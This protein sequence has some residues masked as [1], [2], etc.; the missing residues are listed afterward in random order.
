MNTLHLKY[1]IE[2]E[3]T[4]SISQAA[5]N[6]FMGQPSLSKAIKELEDTLG[7]TIFERT[8][9]GVTPTR[10]GIKFLS[11]ARNVLHQ[12]EQMEA[13][14][15]SLDAG[16][17]TFN[18]SIPR[19]SYIADAVTSL[20]SELDRNE[21]MNVNV[22]ETN[23][24]QVV[25]NIIDGPFNLGVIRF[26]TEYEN[27]FK[28]YLTEK[29]LKFETVWEF[30]YLVLMSEKH[31]LAN[32]GKV[33]YQELRKYTEITHGDTAIP[34]IMPNSSAS[35]ELPSKTSKSIYVYERC[36]QYDLLSSIP[37]TYMWVSPIPEKW[38]QRYQLVQRKCKTLGN[39]YKD[40][41]IYPK[42][43]KFTELDRRFVNKL[44]EAKNDVTFC[45]Y[46]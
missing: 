41:L 35:V 33:D 9:K 43:Y 20:V 40:V 24:V 32:A 13:L 30:E 25:N 1:A 36:S 29:Q 19:G 2:V 42:D 45:E 28:D 5:E 26:Q 15:D 39:I 38:L 8:S 12:I 31:P 21:G 18:I 7:F 3:R 46:R 16:M 17:Q 23:S 27:Y 6:L 14:S 10:K 44:F 11:Y 37:T 4:S 34:Y 22:Q